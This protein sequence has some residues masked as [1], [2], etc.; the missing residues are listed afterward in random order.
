[1]DWNT[2]RNPEKN[3]YLTLHHGVAR[4]PETDPA[5]AQLDMYFG[6]AGLRQRITSIHRT[7]P[8]Q[9]KI[10]LLYARGHGIPT[11][12][13]PDWKD[14]MRVVDDPQY[15]KIF[16]W[17]KVWSEL[18]SRGIIINPPMQARCLM[19][20]MRNGRNMKGSIIY[21]S[22][23]VATW[24][25][26]DIGGWSPEDPTVEKEWNVVQTAI[27]SGVRIRA[28]VERANNCIHCEVV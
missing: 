13:S 27:Q 26:F 2:T 7:P 22:P 18:L 6:R 11:E 1:M 20:Y 4:T 16:C 28:Q 9:L 24:K 12:F 14:I 17:Q 3:R 8:E 10:I 25:C 21:T 5:I 23:H 15:G 19:D